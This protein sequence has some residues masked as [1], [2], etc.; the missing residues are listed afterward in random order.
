MEVPYD[1]TYPDNHSKWFLY[2][3]LNF[4]LQI[5]VNLLYIIYTDSKIIR[6]HHFVFFFLNMDIFMLIFIDLPCTP[7]FKDDNNYSWPLN[8]IGLNCPG[9]LVS[10]LF[11]NK[12]STMVMFYPWLN[13]QIR[14]VNYGTWVSPDFGICGWFWNQSP[15]D[16]KR[17]LNTYLLISYWQ[18]FKLWPVFYQYKQ[19]SK[20]AS[21]C[22]YFFPF[23][24]LFSA[25]YMCNFSVNIYVNS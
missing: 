10:V 13:P 3:L 16:T 5:Y 25:F 14:R 24:W 4:F 20:I 18:T 23:V 9:R 6:T 17:W 1:S 7:L 15:T 12:Y 19:C 2:I 22:I 21:S 8:N 11:F